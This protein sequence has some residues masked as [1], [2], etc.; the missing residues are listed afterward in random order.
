MLKGNGTNMPS[1]TDRFM[2]PADRSRE[3]K[4]RSSKT[5]SAWHGKNKCINVRER[6]TSFKKQETTRGNVSN[7]KLNQL[8]GILHRQ[9]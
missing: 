5:H 3:M 7:L 6:R 2:S 8:M 9:R 4:F 1:L